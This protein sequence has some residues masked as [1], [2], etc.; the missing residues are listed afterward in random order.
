M[1]E[2]WRGVWPS[3]LEVWV[4]PCGWLGS[5]LRPQKLAPKAGL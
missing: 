4:M 5:V 2:R 1:E 3:I